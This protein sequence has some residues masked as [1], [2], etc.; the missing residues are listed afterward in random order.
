MIFSICLKGKCQ[1]CDGISLIISQV[2]FTDDPS[3]RLNIAHHHDAGSFD[4]KNNIVLHGHL[5]FGH[6]LI[7]S[8]Y[9]N[10]ALRLESMENDVFFE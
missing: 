7:C 9:K 5:G 8:L 3:P 1:R 4:P 2:D 10:L 6:P